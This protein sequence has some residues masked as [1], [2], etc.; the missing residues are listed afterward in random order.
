MNIELEFK[1][2]NDFILSFEK[3]VYR[4][5]ILITGSN[6]FLGKKI[7]PLL[8]TVFNFIVYP[9]NE[10]L[11]ISV[12]DLC[13][14]YNFKIDYIFHLAGPSTS[15]DFQELTPDQ[16]RNDIIE[17][18]KK[19]VELARRRKAILV[20]FSSEAIYF[21]GDVYGDAKKEAQDIII[22]SG[23][24]YKI[25]IIPRVYCKS[26]TKGL[27]KNL[28]DNTIPLEDYKKIIEYIDIKD[29]LTQFVDGLVS[30]KKLIQFQHKVCDSIETIKKR[31]LK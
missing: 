4:K 25:F 3:G 24:N 1:N 20:F 28:K 21:P 11:S 2:N 23:I 9:F 27:I 22:S 19:F 7:I 10:R 12:D 8:Q 29:F 17:G 31:Y 30:D 14:R 6:G 5:N 15:H 13:N 26:R 16:I 18:T